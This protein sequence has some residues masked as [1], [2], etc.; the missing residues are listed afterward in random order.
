MDRAPTSP[1]D[2]ANEALTTEITRIVVRQH[3]QESCKLDPIG[4][5]FAEPGIS[6]TIVERTMP[7]TC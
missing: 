5:G 7:N 4:Q 2:N 6:V 1:I 3:R